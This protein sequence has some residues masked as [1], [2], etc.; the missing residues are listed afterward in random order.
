MA[1]ETLILELE[2]SYVP[3]FKIIHDCVPFMLLSSHG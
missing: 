2:K 3:V 1:F